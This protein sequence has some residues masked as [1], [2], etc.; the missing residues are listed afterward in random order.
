MSLLSH[1][2][3]HVN[4]EKEHFTSRHPDVILSF[5]MLVMHSFVTQ[6]R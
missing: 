1:D 3:L 2:R 6:W 5:D 4:T